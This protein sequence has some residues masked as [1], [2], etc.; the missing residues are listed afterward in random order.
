MLSIGNLVTQY[1]QLEHIHRLTQYLGLTKGIFWQHD[2]RCIQLLTH[3]A[4]AFM[5]QIR[6]FGTCQATDDDGIAFP[7]PPQAF[8]TQIAVIYSHGMHT[9]QGS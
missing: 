1:S 8:S 5:P 6:K 9:G 4:D 3:I 2:T 7:V